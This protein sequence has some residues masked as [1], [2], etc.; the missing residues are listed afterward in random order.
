MEFTSVREALSRIAA[1]HV[2]VDIGQKV[3]HTAIVVAEVGERPTAD[4]S[5]YADWRTGRQ[6]PVMES[7]YRVHEL[8]RLALGTPFVTVT[9][10][11]VQM[12]AAIHEMER[13]MRREGRLT[14]YEHTL[15][16]DLWMDATGLGAPIFELVRDALLASTATDRCMVHPVVFNYGDRFKR[17]EYEG[18]GDVLG[19][20]FLVNRLQILLE[21]NRLDLPK[22]DPQ[23]ADMVEELKQ[24]EIRIDTDANEKYGAFIVGAHDDLVTALGLAALEDP[25]YYAMHAGPVIFP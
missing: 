8:R 24:Y 23:I 2:G 14:P 20:A 11:I 15:D 22:S 5:T 18:H 6:V 3:D 12:V 17:G 16:V 19:K 25:G 13:A 9:A 7:T 10:E 4:G 1:V 21:Q